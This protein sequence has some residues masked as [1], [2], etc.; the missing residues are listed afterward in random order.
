MDRHSTT[1]IP[2]TEAP[3]KVLERWAANPNELLVALRGVVASFQIPGSH[4]LTQRSGMADRG[5]VK[6][7]AQAERP[8]KSKRP[9]PKITSSETPEARQSVKILIELPPEGSADKRI[10]L[11]IVRPQTRREIGQEPGDVDHPFLKGEWSEERVTE[12]LLEAVNQ[13]LGSSAAV[14]KSI[15]ITVPPSTPADKRSSATRTRGGDW[16]WLGQSSEGESTHGPASKR[17]SATRSPGEQISG[18]DN[19]PISP[20]LEN[21]AWLVKNSGSSIDDW[22]FAVYCNAIRCRAETCRDATA[23][24]IVPKTLRRQVRAS[25][26]SLLDSCRSV[27]EGISTGRS[28]THLRKSLASVR[29]HIRVLLKLSR[30]GGLH[31]GKAERHPK[32]SSPMTFTELGEFLGAP[33]KD[34]EAATVRSAQ[35]RQRLGV[36]LQSLIASMT[37][38]DASKRTKSRDEAYGFV[39]VAAAMLT[40]SLAVQA[41]RKRSPTETNSC[42]TLCSLIRN[43]AKGIKSARQ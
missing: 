15:E 11:T 37:K 19:L 13:S 2:I 16:I 35:D 31:H 6:T 26:D 28:A 21:L 25:V 24:S 42:E 39:Q 20:L 14:P 4:G 1:S 27:I 17:E 33:G 36:A 7:G 8:R 5:S 10:S 41:R 38:F 43:Q 32:A 18:Q 9:K 34:R 23:E 30:E 22:C 40:E 3:R 29:Q 12:L